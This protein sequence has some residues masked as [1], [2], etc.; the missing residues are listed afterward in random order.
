MLPTTTSRAQTPTK[1]L[2]AELKG[3]K[4]EP[5]DGLLSLGPVKEEDLLQWTAV[6]RGVEGT[7]YEGTSE[8]P[9]I[10]TLNALPDN[11]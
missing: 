11:R 2:L 7:A 6:M 8:L 3:Y 1:R 10:E 4:I 9:I 5:N